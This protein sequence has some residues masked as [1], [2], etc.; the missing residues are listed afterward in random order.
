VKCATMRRGGCD[1]SPQRVD[2]IAIEAGSK[3]NY[4]NLTRSS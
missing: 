4:A 2:R 1:S 3:R